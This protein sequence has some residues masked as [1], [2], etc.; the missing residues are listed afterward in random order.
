[1][2]AIKFKYTYLILGTILFFSIFT[3]VN[4]QDIE[5]N[6]E[7]SINNIDA[8]P[9]VDDSIDKTLDDV[10]LKAIDG[11][12]LY[13]VPHQDSNTPENKDTKEPS[14]NN[15]QTQPIDNRQESISQ[16]VEGVNQ[17]RPKVRETDRVSDAENEQDKLEKSKEERKL[18]DREVKRQPD[19]N[20]TESPSV[21]DKPY[22]DGDYFTPLSDS[23]TDNNDP[24]TI[25]NDNPPITGNSTNKTVVA[26]KDQEANKL[27]IIDSALSINCYFGNEIRS[28]KNPLL[29]C[30]ARSGSYLAAYCNITSFAKLNITDQRFAKDIKKDEGTKRV[31]KSPWQVIGISIIFMAIVLSKMLF[32]AQ[33]SYIYN[34]IKKHYLLGTKQVCLMQNN[35]YIYAI[36]SIVLSLIYGFLI[37]NTVL[38]AYGGSINNNL[39]MQW[40]YISALIMLFL[41]F[42]L[43]C[44]KTITDF[45]E[46][47]E[48][49]D[50]YF[51]ITLKS[52]MLSILILLPIL[53]LQVLSAN[54]LYTFIST[55]FTILA[56]ISILLLYIVIVIYTMLKTKVTIIDLLIYICIF[57]MVP[58]ILI[59]KTIEFY[60][61]TTA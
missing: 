29:E 19:N 9:A 61:I 28:F 33:L 3:K 42:R 24:S 7:N 12:Q 47:A 52:Y 60:A 25:H 46:S 50:M 53:C 56:V 18:R 59:Y 32:P 15:Q 49:F 30:K 54:F 43:L 44:Q 38:N 26:P 6:L 51:C 55:S 1:M 31:N 57:E 45:F 8:D 34:T 36:F 13:K 23:S 48:K 16:P 11:I 37:N 39:I 14:V 10:E 20:P 2:V 22:E 21:S 35:I 40:L 5:N 41:I 27:N 58:I 17:E 4:G